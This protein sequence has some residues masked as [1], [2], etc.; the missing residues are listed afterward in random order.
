MFPYLGYFC[1]EE[2][3]HCQ[4]HFKRGHLDARCGFTTCCFTSSD[5][6]GCR[7][8]AGANVSGWISVGKEDGRSSCSATHIPPTPPRPYLSHTWVAHRSRI[9]VRSRL[10]AGFPPECKACYRNTRW[11]RP[12]LLW[13][14]KVC[15]SHSAASVE[16]GTGIRW[17]DL[18]D[19]I[20]RGLRSH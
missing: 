7:Q 4:F 16:G 2:L 17:S 20:Y 11:S 6:R 13:R 10:A 3:H 19:C 14:E 18:L 9:H 12:P 15:G 8:A 5:T 1:K